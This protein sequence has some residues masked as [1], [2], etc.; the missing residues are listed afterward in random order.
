MCPCTRHQCRGCPMI[1]SDRA[2]HIWQLCTWEGWVGTDSSHTGRGGSR[3]LIWMDRSVSGARDLTL[4]WLVAGGS[5][6][7]VGGIHYWLWRGH[8]RIYL[9][10][11]GWRVQRCWCDDYVV[12]R[13]GGHTP[14]W[15]G[16][17]W[18]VSRGSG[19]KNVI[20]LNGSNFLSECSKLLY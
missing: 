9:W 5:P 1:L 14:V 3:M 12:Q 13:A 6:K 7:A 17:F 20:F 2:I 10:R 8:W 15:W 19:T 11:F 4:F 16:S 18:F